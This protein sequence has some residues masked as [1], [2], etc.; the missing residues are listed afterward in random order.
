M[1]SGHWGRLKPTPGTGGWG[2]LGWVIGV[3]VRACTC[4][5]PVGNG[6]VRVWG[7]VCNCPTIFS[8]KKTRGVGGLPLP[9]VGSRRGKSSRHYES[10][11]RYRLAEN[12]L[13]GWG[14]E[15]GIRF[16]NMANTQRDSSAKNSFPLMR[17]L[18]SATSFTTVFLWVSVQVLRTPSIQ[19]IPPL[20]K[21]K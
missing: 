20:L 16:F 15:T 17:S 12:R 10:P 7:A 5:H 6:V 11:Q 3:C 2:Q 14:E 1:G 19:L 8:K 9:R 21:L 18:N 4:I 13:S